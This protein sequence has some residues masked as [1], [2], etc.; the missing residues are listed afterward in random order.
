M[1]F[2]R[3]MMKN[4]ESSG[5]TAI[6]IILKSVSPDSVWPAFDWQWVMTYS[7]M[8]AQYSG[9][10][11][12]DKTED[13]IF[14]WKHTL[15]YPK[16]GTCITPSKAQETLRKKAQADCKWQR[17]GA[18]PWNTPLD[19]TWKRQS[20]THS[21]SGYVQHTI[22]RKW[23]AHETPSLSEELLGVNGYRSHF[24]QSNKLHNLC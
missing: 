16:G 11:P 15:Y 7:Y 5:E 13:N 9:E 2:S 22:V 17:L 24:L 10:E 20:W 8:I 12:C 1:K 14:Y 19:R 21:S 4:W 18:V 3:N 6:Y 23:G